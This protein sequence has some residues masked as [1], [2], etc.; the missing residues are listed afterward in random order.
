MNLLT[1]S[2]RKYVDEDDKRI[3]IEARKEAIYGDLEEFKDYM[4]YGYEGFFSIARQLNRA[5]CLAGKTDD[6]SMVALADAVESMKTALDAHI[7]HTVRI[8]Q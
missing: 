4:V 6:A 7:E 5:L 1:E 2:L 3:A 8:D